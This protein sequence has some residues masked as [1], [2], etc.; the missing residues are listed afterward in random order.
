VDRGGIEPPTPGFSGELLPTTKHRF[1]SAFSGV[2]RN[3]TQ[4]I[5]HCNALQRV[6]GIAAVLGMF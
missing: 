6:A 4:Q 2:K 3:S 1:S 5:D